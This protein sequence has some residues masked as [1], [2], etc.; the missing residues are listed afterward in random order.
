MSR[1]FA[2]FD[3]DG[4]I[5]RWQLYHALADEL[6][7]TVQLDTTKYE[8]VREAR[9][10]WK[11]RAHETSFHAYEQT[12]VE[13]F[14]DAL[15]NI[16]PEA[17]NQACQTVIKEYKDQVYRYTRDLIAELKGK[18]Y[19]LFAIS[20][21]QE[22]IVKLLAKHYGFDDAGG[23]KYEIKNGR[24]TGKSE[25]LMSERK[26]IFL[27][28]LVAKHGA[29]WQG[30]IGVGDSESDIPMLSTVE[31]PIALNPTKAL[32]EHAKAN[33]WPVFVERKNMIYR[34]E[35]KNGSYILA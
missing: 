33:N 35:P 30:S 29:D 32:F 5:I 22:E 24:F 11:R 19:L 2:V 14:N 1:P 9:L 20:A 28:E 8:Q 15:T 13:T 34:L 21:S 31:Q 25:I 3:I 7:R 12:L 26:P 27:K 18:G 16:S 4:T 10:G 17:L 6:V 23:S